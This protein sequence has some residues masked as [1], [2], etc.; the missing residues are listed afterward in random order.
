MLFRSVRNAVLVLQMSGAGLHSAAEQLLPVMERQLAHMAR[1][2]DDLLDVSRITRGN[3]EVR[4]EITDLRAAVQTAVEANRPLIDGMA[5]ALAV[6]VPDKPLWLD[7]DPVRLTQIVSNLLNNA[8][9]YSAP[10]G[11]IELKVEMEAGWIVVRVRD[12]GVG[13]REQD[14]TAIFGLFVQVGDPDRKSVV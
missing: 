6:S 10:G 12:K 2:L 5:H 1:L 4:K 8:A 14:L 3:I 9:N 11:S 7:G 13:I